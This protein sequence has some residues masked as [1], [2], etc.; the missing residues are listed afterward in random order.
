MHWEMWSMVQGGFTS[1][2]ALRAATLHGAQYLGLDQDLG[3]VAPT[4]LADLAIIKGDPLKEI[5]ESEYVE[6]VILNGSLYQASTMARFAPQPGPAP[7]LF[8]QVE[9]VGMDVPTQAQG[10]C[11]STP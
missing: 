5:K 10:R 9:G 1:H 11:G 8:F 6:W 7:Y 4:Y 3:R 2:Q